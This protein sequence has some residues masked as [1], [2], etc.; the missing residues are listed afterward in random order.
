MFKKIL[1][2]LNLLFL[3]SC[4]NQQLR[5]EDIK[6][7]T[8][9][10]KGDGY[11]FINYLKHEQ[12]PFYLRE[13]EDNQVEFILEARKNDIE[14]VYLIFNETPY[15]MDSIGSIGDIEYFKISVLREKGDYYFKLKDGRLAYYFSSKSENNIDNVEKLNYIPN[16]NFHTQNLDGEIWYNIYIDSFK[17]ANRDNDP[18]FNEFSSEHFTA[19][20]TSLSSGKTREELYTNWAGRRNIKNLGLFTLNNWKDDFNRKENWE[21]RGERI[22]PWSKNASKRF[23]GDIQGIKE[24]L[25]YLQELGVSA[26]WLSPVFYSHSGNK[27]DIIDY[28]HISPDYAVIEQSGLYPNSIR[29]RSEY[30]LLDMKNNERN[31]FN[32]SLDTATWENT[33]SDYIFKDF[34]GEIKERNMKIMLDINFE[35]VSNK[36]FAFEA[37]LMEG[38]KSKYI[39]WFFVESWNNITDMDNI[40][41]W[42]PL[43]LY[44]GTSTI[45]VEER[46][47]VKYRRSFVEV[48][49]AYTEGIKREL[50]T[51]NRENLKYK[52]HKNNRQTVLLN[53]EN[54]VLKKY[55]FEA[56]LKWVNMG[57]DAYKISCMGENKKFYNELESYLKDRN[58]EIV[59]VYD[60]INENKKSIDYYL[61]QGLYQYLAN[62]NKNYILSNEEFAVYLKLYKDTNIS[63][64]HFNVL[65]SLDTDRF[66]SALINP[67]REFDKEN[68]Q[69]RDIY[70]GLRPD[71]IDT[72]VWDK[73]KNAV[74]IQYTLAGSP[75]IYYGSEKGMWGGDTPHN[76]KAMLWNEYLPFANETDNIEKYRSQKEKLSDKIVFDE[77][78]KR[79]SYPVTIN[80]DMEIYYK[81]LNKIYTENK[82][83]FLNGSLDII[84]SESKLLIYERH[85]ENKI[86]IIAVNNTNENISYE[87]EINTGRKYYNPIKEEEID[88][89]ANKVEL[90]VEAK[91]SI[92]LLKNN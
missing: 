20:R 7:P 54:E 85:Y 9:S 16:E 35:Y 31:N 49:E 74:L 17:N 30:S 50:I 73:M 89:I 68:N 34:I 44:T 42:N 75:V 66:V 41:S 40:D 12:N 70:M 10:A 11:I 65:E 51:W 87:H 28:R 71:I 56:S 43:L 77:V 60:N 67:N 78:N 63:K 59:L 86:A 29:G 81:V 91:S 13:L 90:K 38:P 69:D 52:S 58:N 21:L 24:K 80:E 3:I 8:V 36:F 55:L 84:S 23:G 25:D 39:D 18:I 72:K 2:L 1:F 61:S 46:A 22:Y 48:K 76:R 4:S 92:I 26:L 64:N 27:Y 62:N 53:L 79:I 33:E 5:I 47:G 14:K 83:L 15:L 37:L 45:G 19:P 88:V 82:D 6:G 32:E 57:I